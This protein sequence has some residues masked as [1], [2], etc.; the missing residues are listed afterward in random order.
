MKNAAYHRA[1][2][3]RHILNHKKALVVTA[4][5]RWRRRCAFNLVGLLAAALIT[6]ASQNAAAQSGYYAGKTVRIIVGSSAGGGYDTYARAMAP[7]FAEHL[8]GKPT[9]VVQN[10]PGGGGVTAALHLAAGAPRDGP[11]SALL[12]AG[13]ITDVA[14]DPA[15]AQIDLRSKTSS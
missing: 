7:F 8:P 6:A 2:M 9:V 13:V 4:N 5:G 1:S 14:S 15:K 10:M 12:N 3:S 11:A